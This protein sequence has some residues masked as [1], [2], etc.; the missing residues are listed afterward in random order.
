[1]CR[2]RVLVQVSLPVHTSVSLTAKPRTSAP[3]PSRLQSHS[4]SATL[5]TR[6]Q[7]VFLPCHPEQMFLMHPEPRA[8]RRCAPNP[9]SFTPDLSAP[10]PNLQSH[11]VHYT[12][13]WN[14]Q[15]TVA[16]ERFSLDLMRGDAAISKSH[17]RWTE[18]LCTCLLF[19]YLCT[20]QHSNDQILVDDSYLDGCFTSR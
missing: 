11:P 8:A 10:H 17:T 12:L 4:T 5:F 1:M 3:T 19:I 15:Y 9:R 20:C 7:H 6:T 13:G 18:R 16:P 14:A 2:L